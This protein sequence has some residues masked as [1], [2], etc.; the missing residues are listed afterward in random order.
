MKRLETFIKTTLLGGF[1]VILPVAVL[2]GVLSWV[3]NFITQKIQP[4]T[5]LILAKSDLREIVA[6]L[7][8]LV[9]ILAACFFVGLL[10]KTRLGGYIYKIIEAHTL[11]KIPGY[12]LIKETI[13]QFLGDKKSPFSSVAL[14]NIFGN[15][16]L[17]TAFITDEHE[18]GSFTVFIPTGPN[19]T[20]GNI[21]HLQEKYVHK[22]DVSVEM[23][24]KSIISCG[25]GSQEL[26]SG[27][28]KKE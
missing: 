4:I 13:L 20:S 28:R 2:V 19:P 8:A 16:T 18:D 17:V 10:V 12:R 25:A 21:Y 5:N 24:M 6:D 3:F 23:A 27:F 15:E 7:I 11:I 22:I 26:L 9:I 1:V 14:A